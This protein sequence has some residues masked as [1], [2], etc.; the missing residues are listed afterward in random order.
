MGVSNLKPQARK[1]S[2]REDCKANTHLGL[3]SL[4]SRVYR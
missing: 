1:E 3:I 4:G 2:E